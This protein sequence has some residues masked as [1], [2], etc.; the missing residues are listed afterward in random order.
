[1][2][3][4]TISLLFVTAVSHF[5]LIGGILHVTSKDPDYQDMGELFCGVYGFPFA[6]FSLISSG[7]LMRDTVH[8]PMYFGWILSI[9]LIVGTPVCYSRY[10]RKADKQDA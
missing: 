5:L 6:L 2:T 8:V 9:V 3:E 4:D 1:M 7:L 10:R